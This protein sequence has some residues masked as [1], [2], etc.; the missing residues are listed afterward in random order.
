MADFVGTSG[1][2][3]SHGPS[4]RRRSS[5]SS[6]V[7]TL[8]VVA[9]NPPLALLPPNVRTVTARRR[10]RSRRVAH[11]QPRCESR[12]SEVQKPGPVGGPSMRAMNR[13]RTAEPSGA[14]EGARPG[15][16]RCLTSLRFSPSIDWEKLSNT[17]GSPVTRFTKRQP[18]GGWCSAGCSAASGRPG[19]GRTLRPAAPTV[20]PVAVTPGVRPLPKS[21]S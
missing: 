19:T 16:I 17:R 3:P 13:P 2:S 6:P 8:V 12:R 1:S 20:G 21:L 11:R 5:D 7:S 4:S 18:R 14:R 15:S 10:R 9:T